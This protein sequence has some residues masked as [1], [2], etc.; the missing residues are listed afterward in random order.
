M[1][2]LSVLIL[3]KS[4]WK[5]WENEKISK[6]KIISQSYVLFRIYTFDGAYGSGRN[7]WSTV[8]RLYLVNLLCRDRTSLEMKNN[9]KKKMGEKSRR[10]L[11]TSRDFG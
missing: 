9:K 3:N 11:H 10:I 2:F 4:R 1:Q 8:G 5:N 6:Y 7:E